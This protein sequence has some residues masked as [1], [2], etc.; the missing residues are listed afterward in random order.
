LE[1]ACVNIKIITGA[2]ELL[3]ESR[4][5]M[6][7]F[8]DTN[9]VIGIVAIRLTRCHRK[10]RGEQKEMEAFHLTKRTHTS[11]SGGYVIALEEDRRPKRGNLIHNSLFAEEH[12]SLK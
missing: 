2:M 10:K 11:T 5:K 6:D 4:K 9:G 12:L 7:T 3:S 1:V 8:H